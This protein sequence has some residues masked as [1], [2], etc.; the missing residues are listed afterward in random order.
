VKLVIRLLLFAG[1]IA[2]LGGG[3]ASSQMKGTPFYTGE[4]E[5]R[6][7]PVEDR[8]N[9][10]PLLY[11][12]DPALSVLWP[13]MELTD[14][15]FAI[16]P[17]MSI[18]DRK[19]DDPVYNVLW[20]LARFDTRRH[21]HRI[22]PFF[23]GDDYVVGF[24]LYWHFDSPWQGRGYD[25]L[26]PLWSYNRHKKG[27][28]DTHV[29]WPVFNRKHWSD[30]RSGWRIWP[31]AGSY[32]NRGDRYRFAAWPLGHQ[33]S[34]SDG[35]RGG[36]CV[37]P[38]YFQ[39]SRK[40]NSL[41]LSLPY[42]KGIRGESSWETV[43]PL[44]HRRK[45]PKTKGFYSLLYSA[46]ENVEEDESWNLAVPLWYSRRGPDERFVVT[47]AGGYWREGSDKRWLAAPLLSGGHVDDASGDV[48]VGG[49]LAHVGWDHEYGSHHVFPFY[50]RSRSKGGDRF[51]SLLWSSGHDSDGSDWQLL[52]P[53][54]YRHR[55]ADS[56]TL[57]TPLYAQGSADHGETHWKSIVPL[58]F[59]RKTADE[60]LVATLLG[61]YRKTTDSLSWLAYPLLSG[62]KLTEKDKS[63]WA[64]A[65]LIHAR[66][67]NEHAT[68]H[69][70]PLYYWNGGSDT[71]ISLP[72][73][74]WQ[75]NGATTTLVPPALSWMTSRETRKDLWMLGPLAHL[76]W[77]EEAGASH[78]FPLYYRNKQTGSFVS[79]FVASWKKNDTQYRVIPPLLSLYTREGETKNLYAALGLFRQ[80][81]GAKGSGEGHLLPLYYYQEDDHFLSL[82]FGWSH[83]RDGFV[84]PFTPL[85]G[86]R[87]GDYSGGWVFPFWSRKEHRRSGYVDGTFLWG[88][89]RKDGTGGGSGIIPFYGYENFGK[90]PNSI[91]N[92]SVGCNHYGKRFW[93]LPVCWYRNEM[94]VTHSRDDQAQPIERRVQS[95]KKH[96]FFPLWSYARSESHPRNE[97]QVNSSV[98]LLLY[99]Y[100]RTIQDNA[101]T[102]VQDNYTRS[103]VLWRLWHYERI[104]G[105]VCVDIFPAITYDKK[106]DGFKKISFLWRC[107][108]YENG[109]KGKKVDLLFVPLMRRD[110]DE[111]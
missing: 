62:G 56:K 17:L 26:L 2:M 52:A 78:I 35:E 34:E 16:R 68:H 9:L 67:D 47:L 48:W 18:Y 50:Y 33:W 107:F 57:I 43:L 22:F 7:G 25:G 44:Y 75:R 71:F 19:S 82:L 1:I 92:A 8:V 51:Y 96:G 69:V 72:V 87:R 38:L 86:V 49:P 109:P 84:Y 81:W 95:E 100:K 31:L 29:L 23:W 12:R 40:E 13:I 77:G 104:N 42:S 53:L 111:A 36:S 6:Q 27:S 76:S 45:S 37:F 70:L 60:H 90:I 74:R 63:F 41:F 97:K 65:P 46:G 4:Y 93:S 99:D 89:Y 105:D 101:T 94:T 58:L 83:D 11:Y 102:H 32:N 21:K 108:R 28:Y 79:P 59:N 88:T 24:P 20:P 61:G 66:W 85:V 106:A 55:D 30:S 80:Q 14:D 54:M 98:L 5:V 73:A 10:W 39:N 15:H 91:T 103:R 3:C 110:H 64:A